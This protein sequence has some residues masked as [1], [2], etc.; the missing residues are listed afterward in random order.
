MTVVPGAGGAYNRARRAMTDPRLPPRTPPGDPYAGYAALYDLEHASYDED[1][2]FYA[3]LA[4]TCELPVLELGAGTGR[5]ALHLARAGFRVTGID[6]SPEMLAIAKAKVEPGLRRR[7]RFVEA[8]MRD[9]RLKERFDLVI[10]AYGTFQHLHST[11]EQRSCLR[12]VARHLAPGGLFAVAVRPVTSVRWDDA[13]STV[14]LHWAYRDE[15]TGEWFSRWTFSEG[16][17]ATQT[18]RHVHVVDRV[19][20]DGSVR[21]AVVEHVLRYTG[22]YELEALLEDAGLQ[23]DALYGDYDLA[24]YD[25]ASDLLIAVARKPGKA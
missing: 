18:V 2:A 19:G 25:D 20:V 8:D 14:R 3:N 4:R 22:R 5:V 1:L 17:P 11:E 15:K 10:C 21:R 13:D 16:R 7:L 24:P 12:A 23:L 6:S 9:F